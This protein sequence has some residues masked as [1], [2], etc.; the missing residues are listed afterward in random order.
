MNASAS[1]D[2]QWRGRSR[3]YGSPRSCD[4]GWKK[5]TASTSLRAATAAG[6]GRCL[7]PRAPRA[8]PRRHRERSPA[9]PDRR[10]H[11]RRSVAPVRASLPVRLRATNSSVRLVARSFSP[12]T[13]ASLTSGRARSA[14]CRIPSG[15][16]FFVMTVISFAENTT[17]HVAASVSVPA[18]F[19]PIRSCS[20]TAGDDDANTS[21]LSPFRTAGL[22]RHR[23]RA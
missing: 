19:F 3:H 4:A 1:A 11:G 22:A 20:M 5:R 15:L 9:S 10:S 2:A 13:R 16:P 6:N 23:R 17:Y 7:R 21:Q 8:P 12:V 18:T 14:I